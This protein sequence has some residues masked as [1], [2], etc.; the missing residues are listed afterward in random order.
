[1][2][3][4]QKFPLLDYAT[5]YWP[6][7]ARRC[8]N[9]SEEMF[10]LSGPFCR[11]KSLVFENRLKAYRRG[12][13]QSW[14]IPQTFSLHFASYF[15]ILPLAR[16]LLEEKGWK[17][18]F[19]KLENEKD[20][21]GATPL[22][23]AARNGHEAVVQLLLEG[24]ADIDTKGNDGRTA[25]HRAAEGGHEAVVR[26][27]LDSK[28]DVNAKDKDRWTALHVATWR[29]HEGVVRLL[30]DGKADINAKGNDESIALYEAIEREHE[31]IVQLLL[32]SKADVNAK[33]DNGRT[34]LH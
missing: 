12:T 34:A 6:E 9:F 5:L 7:H 22:L 14:G 27:L 8:S 25:L 2:L 16:T 28:A 26:L 32:G 21:S 24:K 4:L 18:I 19:Q 17:T 23:Y 29:G 11:K 20:S 3:H 10:D 15:G 30:L 13:R 33:G 1:M 31:A